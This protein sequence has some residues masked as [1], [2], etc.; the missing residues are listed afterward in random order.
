[1]KR[2]KI[3]GLPDD[4]IQLIKVWLNERTFYVSI[5]GMNSV[6]YDLL[7][8][9]VQGSILGPV[10]YAIFV[11]PLFDL[12][13]MLAFADDNF[14][15]KINTSKECLISDMEIAL[16]KIIKWLSDSGLKVNYTKTELCLFYKND[17]TPVTISLG[18]VNITSSKNINVLGLLFDSKLNWSTHICHTISKSQ[19]SLNALKIIRKYFTTN[20]F[21]MLLTSNY[22]SILYYNSEIWLI[23]SLTVANKKRLL[24]TS[25]NALKLAYNYRL[26][27]ISH[28]AIH[29]MARR[30]TPSMLTNYKLA[31]MLYNLYNSVSYS[32]EWTHLNFEQVFTSRQTCFHINRN[33]KLIVGMNALSSRLNYINDKIPFDLLNKQ[34]DSFKIDCK[35]MFLN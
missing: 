8:G 27:F 7:L 10:L 19:K 6:L 20:E 34:Y 18:G 35:R 31:L 23:P 33:N 15:P 24:S 14:I 1:M 2:L 25:T 17:T 32:I 29:N 26:H 13:F 30:A 21:M 3:I 16:V 11:S 5:D 22:Y 28:I 9:T 12:D 4:V